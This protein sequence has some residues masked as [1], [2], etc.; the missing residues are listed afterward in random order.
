MC[1]FDDGDLNR[2]SRTRDQAIENIRTKS[3]KIE[4]LQT[5][6]RDELEKLDRM[7]KLISKELELEELKTNR[8]DESIK[9]KKSTSTSDIIQALVLERLDVE[10]RKYNLLS[11]EREILLDENRIYKEI[12][13]NKLEL[14]EL[15]N[16]L[17]KKN[18]LMID[19]LRTQLMEEKTRRPRSTVLF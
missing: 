16:E 11:R 1:H 3:K 17:M 18:E 14:V 5:S 2:I 13:M 10:K 4:S 8:I 9:R 15:N 12:E 7:K 6:S 19:K